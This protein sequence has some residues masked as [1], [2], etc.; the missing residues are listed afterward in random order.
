MQ[1]MKI[2]KERA[3][4]L[5]KKLALNYSLAEEEALQLRSELE[6][7]NREMEEYRE[8]IAKLET[9]NATLRHDYSTPDADAEYYAGI[10]AANKRLTL[11][12]SVMAIIVMLSLAASIAKMFGL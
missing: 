10:V 9:E 7:A 11:E 3:Q 2:K 8:R 5:I 1:N 4:K 12:V 6:T